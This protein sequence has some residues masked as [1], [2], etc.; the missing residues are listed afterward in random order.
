MTRKTYT[1]Y[2]SGEFDTHRVMPTHD[3][4]DLLQ[5][6]AKKYGSP[7]EA[8]MHML[9]EYTDVHVYDIFDWC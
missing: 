2:D 5:D 7:N 6:W 9:S 4:E 8:E 3:D 1:V